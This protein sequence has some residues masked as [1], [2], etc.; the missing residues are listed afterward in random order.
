M[1]SITF[2]KILKELSKDLVL[3]PRE[4]ISYQ[5]VYSDVQ[6]LANKLKSE[7]GENQNLLVL[8]ENSVFSITVYLAIIEIRKYLCSTESEYRTRKP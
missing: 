1:F 4:T 3:G 7:F 5:K 8:C 6:K 2:L